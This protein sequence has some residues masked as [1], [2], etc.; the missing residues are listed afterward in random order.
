MKTEMRTMSVQKLVSDLKEAISVNPEYQRG[1]VWSQPQQKKLIDSLLRGYQIPIFYLHEIWKENS[2]G[3]K[4][5]VWEIIDGQQRCD[6]LDRFINGDLTLLDVEDPRS[7]FPIFMRNTQDFP[8]PWSGQRFDTL[9]KELQN[10]LLDTKLQ[11]AYI[12]EADENEI[13]DLFIRLQAGSVLY[14][15]EKRD[16]YPGEFTNFILKLG[17]KPALKLH[18]SPFFTEIM[19][20]KPGDDRGQCRQLA[21]QIS[22]LFFERRKKNDPTYISDAG[23]EKIW[24]YYDT[25]LDFDSSSPDCDR[26]LMIIKFLETLLAGWSRPKLLGHNAIALV[27]F[28]DSIWGDD[29]TGSWAGSFKSAFKEFLKLYAEGLT[30]Y[31]NRESHEAWQEY[32]QFARADANSAASIRRRQEY[33][34]ARMLDFLGDSLVP[35]DPKRL[36]N[37]IEKDYIYLRDNGR[38]QV[39][40][41][42]IGTAP[43]VY[44]HV[45]EHKDGGRTV[46]E[47]GVL[48]HSACHPKGAEVQQFAEKWFEKHPT[49]QSKAIS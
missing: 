22:I 39:C 4:W 8:C 21:A 36:F 35:K 3:D 26:L 31:K 13:R 40:Q 24:E 20:M 47:N 11:I 1:K 41:I 14:E 12:S 2:Q 7:K 17:G 5:R 33:F 10:Q 30:A 32:G 34:S 27:L 48:V 15:Q 18:G 9:D 28:L 6:A 44:H 43:G 25:Q 46:V 16:A 49:Y 38:C 23:S 19:R 42:Q 37:E 29:Y 45:I